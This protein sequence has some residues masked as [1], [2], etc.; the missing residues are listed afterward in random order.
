M[1]LWILFGGI[2]AFS[3]L[4][5]GC[6]FTQSQGSVTPTPTY[7][8]SSPTPTEVASS[9]QASE[10]SPQPSPK[11]SPSSSIDASNAAMRVL[12]DRAYD[13]LQSVF[14]KDFTF[15]ED[16]DPVNGAISF[17]GGASNA[18]FEFAVRI[19]PAVSKEWPPTKTLAQFTGTDGRNKTVAFTQSSL[20]QP[21]VD[22][23]LEMECNS[24]TQMIYVSGSEANTASIPF[25]NLIRTVGNKLV[26]VCP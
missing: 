4:L 5:A 26:D 14:R 12:K 13:A 3:V 15:T 6:V 25:H 10:V 22:F 9:P 7:S 23:T 2:L 19:Y 21:K 20:N 17:G 16:K 1:K 11:A 24:F 18:S 8:V